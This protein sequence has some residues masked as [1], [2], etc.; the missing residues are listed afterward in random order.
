MNKKNQFSDSLLDDMRLRT[1]E[2][3]FQIHRLLLPSRSERYDL[4]IYSPM[5]EA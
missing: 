1:T 2:P 5:H 3:D 4:R